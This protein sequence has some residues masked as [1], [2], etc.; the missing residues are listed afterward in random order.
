M[1]GQWKGS[2]RRAELPADWETAIR[3]RILAR[4][5]YQCTWIEDGVRCTARATDVD[6]IGDKHD[7]SDENLRGIC[8]WH[9][10]KRTAAQGNAA[11]KRVPEKRRPEP[12]PGLITKR[13]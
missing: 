11:R 13:S 9:H 4:D 10:K 6:H 7:H 3:P 1:P 8:D 2:N 5:G 12:H